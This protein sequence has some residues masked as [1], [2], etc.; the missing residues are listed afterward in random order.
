[1]GRDK[2]TIATLS[3][4]PYRHIVAIALQEEFGASE[5]TEFLI[6]W[7]ESMWEIIDTLLA[8]LDEKDVRKIILAHSA[9]PHLF[10]SCSSAR[11]LSVL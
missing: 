10:A 1:M 11:L 8:H 3:D 7:V 2:I 4:E 6:G 9:L 5:E